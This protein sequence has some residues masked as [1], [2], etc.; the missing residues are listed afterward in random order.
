MTAAF[1]QWPA[2]GTLSSVDGDL[3]PFHELSTTSVVQRATSALASWGVEDCKVAAK[4]SLWKDVEAHPV[5]LTLALLD[6]YGQ[7]YIEWAPETLRVTLGRDNIQVSNSAWAKIMAARVVLNSPSP[8]RQWEVFHWCCRGLAGLPNNFTY[9]EQPELAHL[10]LGA[11]VMRL[12]DPT[13]AFNI[14]VEKFTA[15]VLKEDGQAFAPP[16]VDFAQRELLSPQ[17]NCTHCGALHRDDHDVKCISCGSKELVAMVPEFEALRASCEALW[18]PRC[19]LPIQLA[20]ADLPETGPGNLV[21]HLLV[22]YDYARAYRSALLQQ[23]R[24]LAA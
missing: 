10:M 14:E 19:G 1:S 9:L 6:R 22:D 4:V 13:R 16:P 24:A 8:W 11:D 18:K 17:L 21:Y 5:A 23:L 7:D 20:L 3:P 15:A 12:L 2:R